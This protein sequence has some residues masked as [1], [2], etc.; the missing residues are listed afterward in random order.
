MGRYLVGV[1]IVEQTLTPNASTA[2][3]LK[4]TW[5]EKDHTTVVTKL[6]IC[7]H[8]VFALHSRLV[9]LY[10]CV[11]WD[12]FVYTPEWLMQLTVYLTVNNTNPLS[13]FNSYENNLQAHLL[14]IIHPCKSIKLLMYSIPDVFIHLLSYYLVLNWIT[15]SWWV[16]GLP[17]R[18]MS[19]LTLCMMLERMMDG[20][21]VHKCYS[22][23][24]YN[25]E[26]E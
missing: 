14:Y 12:K 8:F 21:F 25:P 17:S 3:L 15:A 6:C 22:Q 7:Y 19:V 1:N 26:L 16:H 20:N 13:L 4:I 9:I 23:Y 11:T 5:P 10:Y 2:I 18:Q 24:N